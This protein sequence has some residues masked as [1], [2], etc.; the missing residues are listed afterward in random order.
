VLP[1]VGL[2]FRKQLKDFFQWCDLGSGYKTAEDLFNACKLDKDGK[3]TTALEVTLLIAESYV[4]AAE[5]Y[6]FCRFFR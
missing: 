2:A 1:K 3:V 4:A 6:L 5:I